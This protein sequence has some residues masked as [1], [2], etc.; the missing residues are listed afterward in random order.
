MEI[1]S[2]F[3]VKELSQ[4]F[5]ISSPAISQKLKNLSDEL[6]KSDKNRTVGIPRETTSKLL[7]ENGFK[8]F[9]RKNIFLA[10][11]IVGGSSKTSFTWSI[12]NGFVRL[13]SRKNPCIIISTDSQAS[14]DDIALSGISNPDEQHVLTDYFN[15]KVSLDEILIP[16]N[17]EENLWIIPSNLNN[18][19]LDKSVEGPSKIKTE[20]LRLLND[21]YAKFPGTNPSLFIDTM[22]AL[23]ASTGS[24]ILAM[25]QLMDK[26]GPEEY[27]PVVCIPLRSDS[28]SLKGCEIA[29]SEMR[30]IINTFNLTQ[31]PSVKIFLANYDKRLSLSNEILK[32]LFSNSELSP[33]VA[34][35]VIRTS[36]EIP[37][38][39]YQKLSIYH[40]KT[41]VVA[42]DYTE[43]LLEILGQ[44][45]PGV[46]AKH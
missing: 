10:H 27:N 39:S 16:L 21:I 46:G 45:K 40:N 15:K 4:I 3:K 11:T 33:H 37:K 41:P 36:S 28:T 34:Q 8:H 44:Q 31:S 23:S 24:F 14:I 32:L 20:A 42:N 6:L 38:A 5:D 26:F 35:T 2:A 1:P 13:S 9:Y 18:V 30:N 19:F 25:A 22:P 29:Y 43:L 12:F 7:S 17:K